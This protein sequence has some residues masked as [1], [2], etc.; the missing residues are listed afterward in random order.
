MQ[1]PPRPPHLAR[2]SFELAAGNAFRLFDVPQLVEKARN[3]ALRN[4]LEHIVVYSVD[5]KI[6]AQ[7]IDFTRPRPTVKRGR[8]AS[9]TRSCDCRCATTPLAAMEAKAEAILGPCTLRY[10]ATEF[11]RVLN[12]IDARTPRQAW[13]SDAAP[14]HGCWSRG[15]R[16]VRDAVPAPI[17]RQN[18][19]N[20][21]DFDAEV[22]RPRRFP[23]TTLADTITVKHW[24]GKRLVQSFR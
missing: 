16:A 10:H 21:G 23:R 17:S 8:C 7:I 13:T 22:A 15:R 5:E 12:Q 14:A 20:S 18:Q 11:T 1:R 2:A 19:A 6:Q 9:I 3:V 4:P 24:R